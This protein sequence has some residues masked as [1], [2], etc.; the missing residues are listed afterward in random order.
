[1][2]ANTITRSS[3][4][5]VLEPPLPKFRMMRHKHSE[6]MQWA[7]TQ[8][9]ARF[10][11]ATSGVGPFPLREMPFDCA[12]LEINGD[13][14]YGYAPL[15][16]AI[17]RKHAVD[18]DCIFTTEG[19]SMANYLALAT[20]L[21]PGAEVLIEQ[22]VY[23]LLLDAAAYI[24]ASIKRF[25]RTEE[26]GWALDP[27]E[28]RRQLSPDTRLIVVT[29]LHNPSSVLAPDS[30][31]SEIAD[32]AASVGAILLVDEVYLDAVYE[33]T[34]RT[35]FHLAAN[36]VVTSSLTKVYG[37]S[38]LRCGWILAQPGLIRAM[39]QLNS[40]FAASAAHPAEIISAAAFE[41]LPVLLNRARKVVDADRASLQ[42]FLDAQT[43]ISA[44]RTEFGTTSFMRLNEGGADE[45]LTRLRAEYDTSAVP[46]RFFEMPSHIRIGMGV[47]HEMFA[48]GLRRIA[49][50]LG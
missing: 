41:S 17:A 38:G 48:E 12:S 31:L 2:Y 27:A 22:P 4:I 23:G 39:W 28:V 21:E 20:L 3:R 15:K 18:P 13:N 44:V 35:S 5:F 29:N 30:V 16:N 10:N 14:T 50:T 36:I 42:S 19:T 49:Q 26:S 45:F 6:Y 9:R 46:G 1:M 40:L 11:L 32:L 34:P 33:N 7:K 24:G 25:A 43:R 37:V 47:D 8:S